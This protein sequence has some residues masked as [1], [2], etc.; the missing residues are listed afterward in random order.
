MKRLWHEL[1]DVVLLRLFAWGWI[2]SARLSRYHN[3]VPGPTF[4]T[5]HGGRIYTVN[6]TD[7]VQRFD[8]PTDLNTPDSREAL[9]Q[10]TRRG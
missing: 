7:P 5:I 2:K 10:L 1:R 6:G 8:L 9:D 4:G 3:F